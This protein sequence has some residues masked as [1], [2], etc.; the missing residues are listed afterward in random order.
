MLLSIKKGVPLPPVGRGAPPPPA[1][2]R[3]PLDTM[4]VGDMFF[5]PGAK[6]KPLDN[7]VANANRRMQPKR[8]SVRKCFAHEMIEGWDVCAEDYPGA[9]QG[10]GVWRTADVRPVA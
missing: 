2:R 4:A 7:L 3:Y 8:F 10:I 5:V 6:R 9:V 1:R